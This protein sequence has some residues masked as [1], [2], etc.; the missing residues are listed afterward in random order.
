MLIP[1]AFAGDSSFGLIL[2]AALS[3]DAVR[4]GICR[5]HGR[6]HSDGPDDRSLTESPS[7]TEATSG[8][9]ELSQ[10]APLL[11]VHVWNN[12]ISA[13]KGLHYEAPRR[14]AAVVGCEHSG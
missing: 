4:G 8:P 12:F 6:R 3:N 1:S 14:Q 2:V 10:R 5:P 7:D 9:Q 11:L 13:S